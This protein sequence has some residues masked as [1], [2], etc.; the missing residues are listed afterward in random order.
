MNV[1]TLIS[2]MAPRTS[3]RVVLAQALVLALLF[4]IASVPVVAAAQTSGVVN[5][6]TA[7]SEQLQ[8]LP[9]V[10]PTVAQRIVEHRES[11]GRFTMVEDLLLVQGIGDRTF[12]LLKPYVVLEGKTTLSEKIPARAASQ[13]AHE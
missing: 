13:G 6:N 7:T 8:Q 4:G 12:D 3:R 10:G 2:D 5:S 1:R 9:R 11:N